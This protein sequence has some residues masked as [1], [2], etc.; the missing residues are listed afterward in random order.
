[1]HHGYRPELDVSREL[2]E[3]LAQRY[4]QMIGILRWAVER[5]LIDI[6]TEVSEL[7]SFNASPREGHLEEAY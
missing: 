4:Q 1:M 5:G 2:N 7:S 6:I 3:K